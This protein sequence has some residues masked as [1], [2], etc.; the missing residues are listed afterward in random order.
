MAL[1]RLE[2]IF[3][4]KPKLLNL[5]LSGKAIKINLRFLKIPSAKPARCN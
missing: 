5:L 4:D 3:L 1:G 2:N